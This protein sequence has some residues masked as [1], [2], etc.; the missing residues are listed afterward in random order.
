MQGLIFSCYSCEYWAP[1]L[2][3]IGGRIEF[4]FA[5]RCEAMALPRRTGSVPWSGL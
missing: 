3:L 1:V 5:V 2:S 4:G